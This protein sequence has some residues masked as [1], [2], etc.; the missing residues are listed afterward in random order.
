[1]DRIGTKGKE[2]ATEYDDLNPVITYRHLL[3]NKMG[4]LD[5]LYVRFHRGRTRL[6]ALPS[7]VLW[8]FAT[9]TRSMQPQNKFA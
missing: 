6:T 5:P 2:K 4:V 1:M 7:D 3:T 9:L 8:R